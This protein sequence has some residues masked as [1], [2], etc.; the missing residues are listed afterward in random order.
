MVRQLL[1]Q[2][3]R[4]SGFTQAELARR[5]GT[6]QPEVARLESVGS[7]PRIDT[8]RRAVEATGHRLELRALPIVPTVDETMIVENLALSSRERLDQFAAAYASVAGLAGRARR[9]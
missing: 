8:L 1:R 2:A 6:A 9:A 4:E 3:R 7:N 5:M